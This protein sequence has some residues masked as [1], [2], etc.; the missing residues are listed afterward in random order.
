MLGRWNVFVTRSRL[1][2]FAAVTSLVVALVTPSA[3]IATDAVPPKFVISSFD[4]GTVPQVRATAAELA[5]ELNA[6]EWCAAEPNA[7]AKLWHEVPAGVDPKQWISVVTVGYAKQAEAYAFMFDG[8][9]GAARLVAHAPNPQGTLRGA[10]HWYAPFVK[11]LNGFRIG[12]AQ[13]APSSP[14][15]QLEIREVAAPAAAAVAGNKPG[16]D[17]ALTIGPE[18]IVP[19]LKAI[20][21]AAACRG[22]WSPTFAAASPSSAASSSTASR[23]VVELQVLDQA[24]SFQIKFTHEG[25]E[26]VVTKD[27]VPWEEFHD[28]LVSL[29]RLP[30][31]DKSVRDLLRLAPGRVELLVAA[32]D[33]LAYLVDDELAALD[34]AT[35]REAWRLRI[36]QSPVARTKKIERYVVRRDPADGR[37]RLFRW[38]KTLAE[39]SLLDGSETPFAPTPTVTGWS[40][41]VDGKSGAITSDGAKLTRYV[42]GKEVWSAT[43]TSPLTAGPIIAGDR[44]LAATDRG[45]LFALALS[46]GKPLWRV[47]SPQP[48]VGSI[49]PLGP[50]LLA[51]SPGD[52]TLSAVDPQ[53]GAT[54]WRFAA[55]DMLLQAPFVHAGRLIVVTKQN[56]IAALDPTSGSLLAETTRPT[57]LVG[58]ESV[59]VDKSP[60]LAIVDLNGRAA[61]LNDQL[62][63][64]WQ[65][66]L[67]SRPTG[68]PALLRMP[69]FWRTNA[70][71]EPKNELLA[72]V[73][74]DSVPQQ[75]FFLTT[76]ADGFLYKLALPETK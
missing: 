10:P 57:W 27:R 71:S 50:M 15:L 41:D 22:G 34:T 43:E 55:G 75:T 8:P 65:A 40:F 3:T 21:L 38:T 44:V 33:R 35:G 25:T 18:K 60:Q 49:T 24:C 13:P 58:V 26:S 42:A 51:F 29:F 61:L 52:E 28:Q 7:T 54:K 39:I 69:A 1:R 30:L 19:P 53:D 48:I 66:Q 76:D 68:R 37:P 59:L 56:R 4:L 73:E 23:A 36:P 31:G 62:Q 46:D 45:E 6:A 63:P 11:L 2:Q 14:P 20:L 70:K 67:A 16:F 5:T 64:S 32:G 17:D 47:K 12:Y 9:Q 72:A 74:A